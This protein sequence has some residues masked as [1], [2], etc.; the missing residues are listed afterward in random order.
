MYEKTT[1]IKNHSGL[2]ARPASQ[3]IACAKGFKSKV[4]ISRI[5]GKEGVNAKSIIM[6]LSIGLGKG[7][8]VN[9]SADGDD[10]VQAVDTLVKLIE[11]GFGET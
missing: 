11:S 9:I 8:S 3:F 7:E 2:H 10:E 5:N 4:T 1:T 6:L